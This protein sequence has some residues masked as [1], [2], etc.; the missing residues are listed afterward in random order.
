MGLGKKIPGIQR[1]GKDF[2]PCDGR[3]LGAPLQAEQ[4][5]LCR[6]GS[7]R[8]LAHPLG[9][10][11]PGSSQGWEET[12]GQGGLQRAAETIR[13]K[14]ICK[15]NLATVRANIDFVFVCFCRA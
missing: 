8:V 12:P 5:E 9:R 15:E 11:S 2:L 6:S 7:G 3:M 14:L 10:S 13:Q 1:G 4:G